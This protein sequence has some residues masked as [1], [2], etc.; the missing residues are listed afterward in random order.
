MDYLCQFQKH[1]II[2]LFSTSNYFTIF[3]T[4]HIQQNHHFL[5]ISIPKKYKIQF[6]TKIVNDFI[7]RNHPPSTSSNYIL[8][9]SPRSVNQFTPFHAQPIF[10]S[11]RAGPRESTPGRYL[12]RERSRDVHSK[13]NIHLQFT[14]QRGKLINFINFGIFY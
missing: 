3:P 7:N 10:Q 14:T 5:K 4:F 12:G 1:S 6:D 9:S 13:I 11:R 8:V 2:Y